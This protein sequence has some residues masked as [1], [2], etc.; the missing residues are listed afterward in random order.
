MTLRLLRPSS[1]EAASAKA[2][3]CGENFNVEQEMQLTHED[4]EQP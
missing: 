3:L 2:G 4:P 1:A